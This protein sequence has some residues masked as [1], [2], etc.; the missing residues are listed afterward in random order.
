MSYQEHFFQEYMPPVF[1]SPKSPVRSFLCGCFQ[2]CCFI[3]P[4]QG[5][6]NCQK[7]Y[8]IRFYLA[9]S[10][11]LI[12]HL[13]KNY[14]NRGVSYV[15]NSGTREGAKPSYGDPQGKQ[16]EVKPYCGILKSSGVRYFLS[17]KSGGC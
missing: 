3:L 14:P 10:L 12:P 2:K 8:W 6:R 4:L 15:L 11:S 7:C 13:C 16:I 9:L 1:T 5:H 17:S